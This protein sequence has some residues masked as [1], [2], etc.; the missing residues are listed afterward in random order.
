MT[1]TLERLDRN[2]KHKPDRAPPTSTSTR[3]PNGD[4]ASTST[5]TTQVPS[6]PQNEAIAF[7]PEGDLIS[8]SEANGGAL[9]PLF[10]LRGAT[11]LAH[12]GVATGSLD[13]FSAPFG[14]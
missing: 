4:I 3:H 12:S 13:R 9:P 10:V 14:S 2:Y 7:T 8:G 6:Q 5:T 1:R 11:R